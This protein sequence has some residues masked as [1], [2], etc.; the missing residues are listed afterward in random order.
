MPAPSFSLKQE[1]IVIVASLRHLQDE[2]LNRL[3]KYCTSDHSI[4]M[5]SCLKHP[6]ELHIVTTQR[7]LLLQRSLEMGR[8]TTLR[9]SCSKLWF[10]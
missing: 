7:H 10:S 5:L 3:R 6:L 9:D 4:E 8:C 1:P 2:H